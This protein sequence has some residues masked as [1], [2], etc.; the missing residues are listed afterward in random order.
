M[1]G[2]GPDINMT[3]LGSFCSLIR[4]LLSGRPRPDTVPDLL[5]GLSNPGLPSSL[6]P[7]QIPQCW[8][9]ERM[10]AVEGKGRVL[11]THLLPTCCSLGG[12]ALAATGGLASECHSP[13]AAWLIALLLPGPLYNGI[14]YDR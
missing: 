4:R 5:Q 11:P 7:L 3:P 14:L 1:G 13:V 8:G 9:G 6:H 10:V 2:C 12:S